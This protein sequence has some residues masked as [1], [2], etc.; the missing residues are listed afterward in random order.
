MSIFFSVFAPLSLATPFEFHFTPLAVKMEVGGG[1]GG[2]VDGLLS[3][4]NRHFNSNINGKQVPGGG[5]LARD[6]PLPANTPF[7]HLTCNG[8]DPSVYVCM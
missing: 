8:A 3:A 6:P 1:R 2:R 7:V 5:S 4:F